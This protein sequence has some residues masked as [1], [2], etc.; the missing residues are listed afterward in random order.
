MQT[1]FVRA[2]TERSVLDAHDGGDTD[3]ELRRRYPRLFAPDRWEWAAI[4]VRFTMRLPRDDLVQSVHVVAFQ[5]DDVVVC[6]DER[7]LVWFLPGGTREVDE[8]VDSCIRREFGEEAG[9]ELVGDFHQFGAH[10][11]LSERAEPYRPHLP[12]PRKAWLWGWAECV[13]GRLP[14]NPAGGETVIEVQAVPLGVAMRL[15]ST[16]NGWGGELVALA[17]SLRRRC[18]ETA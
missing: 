16:D 6:R 8:T 7:P 12:H 2:S 9:G 17:A 18:L 11:G 5:G 1:C 15:A 3:A 14:G 10:V 13:V 4:D